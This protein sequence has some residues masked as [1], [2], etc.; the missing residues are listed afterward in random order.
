MSVKS[1]VIVPDGSRVAWVTCGGYPGLTTTAPDERPEYGQA[2]T[3][4]LTVLGRSFRA[5]PVGGGLEEAGRG[6]LYSL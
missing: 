2:V 1:K 5:V 3:I 4:P 6:E